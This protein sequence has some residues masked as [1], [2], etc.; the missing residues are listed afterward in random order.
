VS[1][2]QVGSTARHR[3]RCA[4]RRYRPQGG[5]LRSA[6]GGY[7][8]ARSVPL[9]CSLRW[10]RARH[11]PIADDRIAV[12][13]GQ[14]SVCLGPRPERF[15]SGSPVKKF[16]GG[17]A[18]L[19][20]RDVRGG[21][22]IWSKPQTNQAGRRRQLAGMPERRVAKV[23]CAAPDAPRGPVEPE[24]RARSRGRSG[25]SSVVGQAGAVVIAL[26]EHEKLGS[27]LE[28]AETGRCG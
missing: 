28:A 8:S 22:R 3:D 5:R 6:L 11:A 19:E 23:R 14:R 21:L 27:V 1:E 10:T 24:R 16:T 12:R 25:T 26:V 17:L 20:R 13:V 15:Q 2:K 4:C 9:G 18:P 7:H